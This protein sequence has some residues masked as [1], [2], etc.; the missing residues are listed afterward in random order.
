MNNS[1]LFLFILLFIFCSWRSYA[2]DPS[3]SQIENTKSYTHPSLFTM[4]QGI[5]LGMAHR[6][7]WNKLYGDFKT[8]YFSAFLQ[9]N[10][11]IGLGY[12]ITYLQDEEGDG[13]LKTQNF[14]LNIRALRTIGI[15]LPKLGLTISHVIISMYV[16]VIKKS[17]DWSKLVFSDQIDPVWGIDKASGQSFPQLENSL[18]MTNGF[19]FTFKGY[20]II[21]QRR[22][23]FN[24]SFD[25]KHANIFA[26][27]EE[28]LL[29]L[30]ALL[31]RLIAF[32]ASTTFQPSEYYGLPL[33]KPVLRFESQMGIKRMEYGSLIG[34]AKESQTIYTGLYYSQQW[35]PFNYLN[36]NSFIIL[37]GFEKATNS[38]LY[39][40]GYSY[41][42]NTSGFDNR[43]SGGTH[44][45]TLN[46]IFNT[47]KKS[48]SQPSNIFERCGA[49]F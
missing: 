45:I 9:H 34:L 39:T 22:L 47:S 14:N 44:E 17:I 8:T 37:I 18:I 19:G 24:L 29:G 35:S 15:K 21:S 49:R 23:P 27:E 20:K 48:F 26:R 46:I 5:E 13:K 32:T 16:G 25:V 7:Q 41:D 33:L 28:S 42:F 11:R 43:N 36:A 31:P 6:I 12:G 40:F 4:R 2:Q 10:E 30:H 3:F 38:I 1:K